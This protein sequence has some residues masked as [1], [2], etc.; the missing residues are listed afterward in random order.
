MSKKPGEWSLGDCDGI[1]DDSY[2]WPTIHDMND[3]DLLEAV[4]RVKSKIMAE[5][6]KS[7]IFYNMSVQEIFT[8]SLL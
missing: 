1:I 2:Q 6:E 3:Q 7:S 5:K 4:K 8:S